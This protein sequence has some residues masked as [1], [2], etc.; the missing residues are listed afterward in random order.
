[1]LEA[2][3]K[4]IKIAIIFQKAFVLEK[5]SRYYILQLNALIKH[6]I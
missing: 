2:I 1:M 5:I 4:T 6:V 3:N